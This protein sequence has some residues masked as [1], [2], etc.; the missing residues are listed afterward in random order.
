M[1]PRAVTASFKQQAIQFM[2]DPQ[3][4]IPSIVSPFLFTM[5]MLYIHQDVTGPVVLQAVLG[6][7]VLGMWANTIFASSFTI[8]Y[9]RMNGTF[10][11]MLLSP[12]KIFDILIGRSIWN[13]FIGLVNALL[14][15]AIAEMIFRTGVSLANPIGFF[16]ILAL[17]LMS[18]ASFGMLI[19]TAF[20]FSRMGRFFSSVAEYPIYVISGA[21]VPISALPVGLQHISY[22]LA[23]SWGVDAMRYAAFEGYGSMMGTSLLTDIIMM[24]MLSIAVLIIAYFIMN[25]AERAILSAGSATRY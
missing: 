23:P 8:S 13:A 25:K 14:V 3:W 10:E 16:F 19:S 17:T 21:L 15:F 2:A 1:N 12:T 24:V 20:V 5:V 18:L 4:I 9:D 6:G 11:S 22:L 7:G